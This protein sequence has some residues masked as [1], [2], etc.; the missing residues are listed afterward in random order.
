MQMLRQVTFTLL[1]LGAVTSV[2]AQSDFLG[3]PVSGYL[4]NIS[5]SAAIRRNSPYV[6]PASMGTMKDD[7]RFWPKKRLSLSYAFADRSVDGTIENAQRHSGIPELYLETRA[8]QSF[9]LAGLYTGDR[10]DFSTTELDTD[11]FGLT[12]QPAQELWR[13]LR[14]NDSASQL[15]VGLGTGYRATTTE[16]TFTNGTA[17]LEGDSF[18][19][20]PNLIYVREITERL[21]GMIVTAYTMEWR[22]TDTGTMDRDDER[23]LFTLT[24]RGDFGVTDKVTLTAFATW[25]Q[26]VQV[27][28]DGVPSSNV[29]KNSWAEF[30][31]SV[32]YAITE[33][34]GLRAGY[35]YEAF[36]PNFDEHKVLLRLELGF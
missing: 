21:S 34:I 26:E 24:G 35:S 11:V 17:E 31:G 27:E 3:L 13:F 7:E 18:F 2:H 28:L 25:K 9:H 4:D 5:D 15:W 14:P 22:T 23:G 30:G 8:G 6:S 29:D 16:F 33:D 1:I 20:S 32:R 19:I 10:Q 36:H 12:F